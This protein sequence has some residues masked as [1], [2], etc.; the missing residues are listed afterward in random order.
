MI[1]NEQAENNIFAG[2]APIP[3]ETKNSFKQIVYGIRLVPFPSFTPFGYD[4]FFVCQKLFYVLL[5]LSWVIRNGS[6][7]SDAKGEVF[8]VSIENVPLEQ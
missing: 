3:S 6:F 2:A 8:N 7:A 1:E 5:L 4:F